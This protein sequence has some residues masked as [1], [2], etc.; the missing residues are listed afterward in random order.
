MK[1]IYQYSTLSLHSDS[2]LLVI[3]V[4]VAVD[5]TCISSNIFTVKASRKC[6]TNQLKQS[7]NH[8]YI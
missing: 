3:L 4:H 7:T 1:H 2:L 8:S 5:C 6:L